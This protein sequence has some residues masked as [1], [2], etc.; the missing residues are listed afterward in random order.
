M[1]SNSIKLQINLKRLINLTV[2]WVVAGIFFTIIE[3]L[4]INPA[5]QIPNIKYL[6]TDIHISSYDFWRSVS[7]TVFGAIVAGLSI[8]A[9]EIFYFQ[10]RFRKKSFGYTVFIKSLVYSFA[11]VFLIIIGIFFD[12]GFNGKNIFNPDVAKT[13]YISRVLAY[14]LLLYTGLLL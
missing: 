6:T 4:L 10:D 1:I 8:G 13:L 2:A 9:F 5:A 7:T 11:M 14:G 3:F 12:Q